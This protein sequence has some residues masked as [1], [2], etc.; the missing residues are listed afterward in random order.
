MVVITI[1]AVDG[2]T[3]T[4]TMSG[5]PKRR[6]RPPKTPSTDKPKFQMHLLKKPKYLQ[7]VEAVV[8]V[9]TPVSGRSVASRR[10]APASTVS[11]SVTLVE[12]T[13]SRT[14]RRSVQK[15][16]PSTVAKPKTIPRTSNTSKKRK[17][18]AAV[19]NKS[20]D[21]HYGS[22]FEES[23]K[24]DL[25]ETE[26]SDTNAE[27]AD[28]VS[29]SDFSV[30]GFS[31]ASRAR[32]SNVSY[33]RNPSPEPLWL[34][35]EDIPILEIPKSSEDLLVPIEHVMQALCIYEVLRRFKNQVNNIILFL[36]NYLY[37]LFKSLYDY[38]IG[39]I[40]TISIRGFLCSTCI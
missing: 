28:D 38:N 1:F 13:P 7:N 5:R 23:D 19:S 32:K 33:I 15:S 3:T 39:A 36:I 10:S 18:V 4:R 34:R 6:G 14:T 29:D 30:S 26:Q 21:Y 11:Q 16:K 20:H 12:T 37:D 2:A 8:T 22:D 35:D 40:V 9:T 17:F 31:V 25:S 24:S 27:D